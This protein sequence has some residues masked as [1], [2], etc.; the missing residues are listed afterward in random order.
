MINRRAKWLDW[1]ALCVAA[2]LAM[3][4]TT[5]SAQ[6]AAAPQNLQDLQ[7]WTK[8][9]NPDATTGEEGCAVVYRIFANETTIILQMSLSYLLS[10]PN[11]IIVSIWIPTGVFVD[12]GL[13]LQVD[14]RE[15]GLVPFRLCDP[16]ICIAE[17][18]V[19]LAFVNQLKA[20][21]NLVVSAIVPHQTEGVQRIDLPVSL[22]GFTATFDGPGL[23]PDEAAAAQEAVNQALLDRA[24]E[25]RQRLIQQQQQ[26]ETNPTPAP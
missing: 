25:A 3:A 22:T 6:E 23:T 7:Q 9:C 20:G 21:L 10:D 24:E 18:Q 19:D 14:D 8:V 5:A 1:R 13:Q 16:Q 12:Q 17:D 26:L 4:S 15:P 2:G 11:N